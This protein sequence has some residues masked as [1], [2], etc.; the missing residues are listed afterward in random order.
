MTEDAQPI[1]IRNYKYPLH[2]EFSGLIILTDFV[3]KRSW[4]D[5][6]QSRQKVGMKVGM[7]AWERS[8]CTR[9]MILL[10]IQSYVLL[11]TF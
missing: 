2:Q 4:A 3:V 1:N 8:N 9:T 11:S 7:N 5:N 10:E 6:A